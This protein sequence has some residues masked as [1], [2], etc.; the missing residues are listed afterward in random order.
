MTLF[1]NLLQVLILAGVVLATAPAA[2]DDTG[3]E[4]TV[5]LRVGMTFGGAGRHILNVNGV[6][7]GPDP[8]PAA[9]A[10][11]R[12]ERDAGWSP[13]AVILAIGVGLALVVYVAGDAA[14]DLNEDN[15]NDG[16]P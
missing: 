1:R 16:L 12:S 2:A 6:P 7:L 11:E 14:E 5:G 9:N 15:Q 8:A 10:T 13:A 3:F 4:P